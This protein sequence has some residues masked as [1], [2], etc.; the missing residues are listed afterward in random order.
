MS[1]IQVGLVDTTGNINVDLMQS[2]AVALNVQVT[3]DLPQFW[4]VK[5]TVHYL[6]HTSHLPAGVWP[7]LLV[8]QLPDGEGGFHL[9]KHNQPYAKVIASPDSDEWTI[10]ASHETIEMLIDPYGN[11]LQASESLQIV[12]NKIEDG[13]GEFEYLVEA[14][15]PCEADNYAYPIQ[16]IMVSDFITPRF[17]DPTTMPGTQYS[18]TG[19]VKAPRQILPGGY[20]S[21]VNTE[22]DRIQQIL[23]VDPSRPPVLRDLGP[24]NARSLREWV[25]GQTYGDVK[26]HRRPNT[27]MREHCRQRRAKLEQF[28]RTRA[29]YYSVQ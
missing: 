7:V 27:G 4:P 25:D 15:D 10:D 2:V 6:P 3:R 28:A 21:F 20:I 12:D 26:R 18:Y 22:L 19:A 16:G 8:K 11:K 14:C 9:N 13:M 24:A 1:L 5:A 29:R 17:Y 23:W